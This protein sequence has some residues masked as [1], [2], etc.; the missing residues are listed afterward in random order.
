M[1]EFDLAREHQPADVA[2]GDDLAVDL[3]QRHH[4]RLEAPIGGE[5]LGVARRAVPETEVLAHRHARRLQALHQNVVDEL[6]GGLVRKAAIERD[7][8][9]I[10]HTQPADQVGL[11]IEAGEEFRSSLG[12]DDLQRVRLEREHGVGTRDHLSVAEVNAVEF[13]DRDPAGARLYVG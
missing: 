7:H 12:P 13:A 4:P 2:R 11:G 10:V 5:H 1:R 8:D 9:Q 3:D 6:F